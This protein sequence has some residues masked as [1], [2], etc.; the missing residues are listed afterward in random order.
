LIYLYTFYHC[1]TSKCAVVFAEKPNDKKMEYLAK[2]EEIKNKASPN[3][4]KLIAPKSEEIAPNPS[5][6]SELLT[7]SL[8]QRID[9][10]KTVF[11]K[12]LAAT[13][14][15]AVKK[16]NVQ[17]FLDYWRYKMW[18]LYRIECLNPLDPTLT[19]DTE[20]QIIQ[21]QLARNK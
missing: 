21:S 6:E 13:Y 16:H 1:Y 15:A 8:L 20:R 5:K 17:G 10:S 3:I 4:Q 2:L 12:P 11:T 19:D 18:N 7:Q 9:L 14:L